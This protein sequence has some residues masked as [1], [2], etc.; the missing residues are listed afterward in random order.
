VIRP[1]VSALLGARGFHA[2]PSLGQQ[3]R[4]GTA[5]MICIRDN[6]P[7]VFT[8]L[9]NHA[10]ALASQRGLH[11]FAVGLHERDPLVSAMKSFFHVLYRS[12][13]YLVSWDDGS[14]P[15]NTSGALV[16]YLELGTL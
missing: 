8:S 10:L 5:A 14:T 2:L 16:P 9:L 13:V 12:C 6:D 4:Y 15:R 7:T 1:I 3:V 11:Q